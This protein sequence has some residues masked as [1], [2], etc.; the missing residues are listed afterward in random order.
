MF[1]LASSIFPS[2]IGG[3]FEEAE[4]TVKGDGTTGYK[5]GHWGEEIMALLDV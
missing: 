5:E 3:E 1:A 4:K 2:R